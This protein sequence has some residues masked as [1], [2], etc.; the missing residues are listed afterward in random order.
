MFV[1]HRTVFVRTLFFEDLLVLTVTGFNDLHTALRQST[2]TIIRVGA[3]CFLPKP[4]PQPPSGP[5]YLFTQIYAHVSVCVLCWIVVTW[6]VL[7]EL[8]LD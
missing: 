1:K 2:H 7:P 8:Q 4:H 3:C 5:P 6:A